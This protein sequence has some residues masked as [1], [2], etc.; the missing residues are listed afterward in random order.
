MRRSRALFPIAAATLTSLLLLSIFQIVKSK[1]EVVLYEFVLAC[2]LLYAM[3]VALY[4][5]LNER[6]AMGWYWMP[7]AMTVVFMPAVLIAYF[8]AFPRLMNLEASTF[9]SSLFSNLLSA[10]MP[11]EFVKALPALIGLLVALRLRRKGRPGNRFTRNLAVDGPVDGMLVGAA[12]GATFILLET[13]GL[14]VPMQMKSVMDRVKG[15]EAEALAS[16]SGF[17]LLFPRVLSGLV[18]HMAWA[19]ISGY[20]IGLVAGHPRAWWKLLP[21]AWLLPATLHSLWN[22]SAMTLGMWALYLS[23]A[24]TLF[25]FIACAL[26]AKQL[27]VSRLG[28]TPDGHSILALSPVGAMARGGIVPPPLPGFAGMMTGV[29]TAIEKGVGFTAT[30]TVPGL[31]ALAGPPPLPHEIE[32]ARQDAEILRL[33]RRVDELAGILRAGGVEP[34]P[35]R[36][37]DVAP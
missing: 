23:S 16:L 21:I 30:T 35:E 3:F 31:G 17:L 22:A 14:Y 19:G 9:V 36:A 33:R 34:P 1:T 24:I 32:L 4:H 28:T 27:E 5:Y 15:P 18:G 11:E 26:K 10:G 7:V 29:A 6:K 20:F 37:P 8:L 12:A 2:F 25:L 13:V